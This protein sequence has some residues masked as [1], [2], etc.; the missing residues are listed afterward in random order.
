MTF[1]MPLPNPRYYILTFNN[2]FPP[3]LC[4]R[5]IYTDIVIDVATAI[6]TNKAVDM[7][8][9]RL[10]LDGERNEILRRITMVANWTGLPRTGHL[11]SSIENVIQKGHEGLL[12]FLY[13][14]Q[15]ILNA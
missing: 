2:R 10:F 1:P 6:D 3:P 11:K 15:V 14:T 13:H 12:P 5:N 9:L 4:T 7:R 8:W